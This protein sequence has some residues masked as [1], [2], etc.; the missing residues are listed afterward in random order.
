MCIRDRLTGLPFSLP[1]EAQWEY[2]AAGGKSYPYAG[3]DNI[4]DVAYYASNANA[5]SYTHL[6]SVSTSYPNT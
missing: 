4:R 6:I 5:V 3:S 1:T 2:A